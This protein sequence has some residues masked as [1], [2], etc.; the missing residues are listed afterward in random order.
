MRLGGRNLALILLAILAILAGVNILVA[1]SHFV[2]AYDAY[3]RLELS[4]SQFHFTSPD[5]PVQTEFVIN[6]PSGEQLTVLAIELRVQ[7]GVHDIGGGEARP[8]TVLRSGESMTVPIE[9]ALND[10]N[11]VRTA[12]QPIDWRVSGRVQVQLKPQLDP[13]W[14]PFV[15]RYLPE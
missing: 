15:V 12:N 6:N 8:K 7:I 2:A 10:K 1:S 3:D 5:D 4:L 9:L 14:V 13:V 11:Y